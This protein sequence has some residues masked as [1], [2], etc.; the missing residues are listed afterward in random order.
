MANDLNLW[1]GIGRLAR[2]PDVGTYGTDGQRAAFTIVCNSH[3]NEKDHAEFIPVTAF[4]KLAEIVGK[5]LFQGSQCYVSGKF[6]TRKWEKED[7]S[8]FNYKTEI[9]ARE[10]QFLSRPKNSNQDAG[11]GAPAG[12]N[13]YSGQSNQGNYPAGNGGY[14]G[15]SG[16]Q[17]AEDDL[18]F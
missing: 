11:N 15:P 10:V 3:Y 2:D 1:Q 6:Q 14:G 7:G 18:P 13:N 9:I 16:N 4:G 8:G 5:Y 12:E 17:A